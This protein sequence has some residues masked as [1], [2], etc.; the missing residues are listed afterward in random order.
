MMYRCS[1]AF[2]L[3]FSDA[4]SCPMA[5][6]SQVSKRYYEEDDDDDEYDFEEFKRR[7]KKKRRQKTKSKETRNRYNSN[8][9]NNNNNDKSYNRNGYYDWRDSRQKQDDNEGEG[10]DSNRGL[11]EEMKPKGEGL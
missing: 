10:Y 2:F 7:Q 1:R 9:N 8:S 6:D 4:C 11:S 3:F 5:Q